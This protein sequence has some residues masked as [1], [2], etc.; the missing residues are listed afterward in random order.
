MLFPA[1]WRCIR[2]CPPL[3]LPLSQKP[4][5]RLDKLPSDCAAGIEPHIFTAVVL[6]DPDVTPWTPLEEQDRQEALQTDGPRKRRPGRQGTLFEQRNSSRVDTWTCQ[7]PQ[8]LHFRIGGFLLA[9]L[10]VNSLQVSPPP[11]IATVPSFAIRD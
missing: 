10:D 1:C 11:V 8:T 7:I 9:G 6:P 4:V 3:R 5:S 2:I